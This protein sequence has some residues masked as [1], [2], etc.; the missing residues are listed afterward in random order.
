MGFAR[1]DYWSRLPCPTPGDLPN[2]GSE[3][4]SLMS[5]A[6][7]GRFFPTSDT[8]EDPVKPNTFFF[9]METTMIFNSKQTHYPTEGHIFIHQ[10]KY[11]WTVGHLICKRPVVFPIPQIYM[12]KS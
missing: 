6:L 5:P 4:A 2:P 3:L 11:T 10:R 12:L 9:L 7:A 8:W 1:Q